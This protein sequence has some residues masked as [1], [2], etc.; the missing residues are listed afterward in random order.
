MRLA[1]RPIAGGVL[2]K[3]LPIVFVGALAV[4]LV[5][6]WAASLRAQPELTTE[7]DPSLWKSFFERGCSTLIEG[8]PI[9]R[10]PEGAS[11]VSAALSSVIGFYERTYPIL[12]PPVPQRAQRLASQS[13]SAMGVARDPGLTDA[14]ARV[15]YD[16][17]ARSSERFF[18]ESQRLRKPASEGMVRSYAIQRADIGKV[19]GLQWFARDKLQTA[20]VDRFSPPVID[21]LAI[22]LRAK[23]PVI[24]VVNGGQHAYVGVG[25]DESRVVVIDHESA[26]PLVVPAEQ[27]LLTEEDRKSS[28]EF[29]T[30]ARESLR[31]Q[32]VLLDAVTACTERR[33]EGIRF[34]SSSKLGTRVEMYT[35]SWSSDL[36]AVQQ[37]IRK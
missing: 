18:A 22:N 19:E 20:K 33:I 30:K 8:V 14:V 32:M 10:R 37:L 36:Y 24:I 21:I 7:N 1:S 17:E 3:R 16:V 28:S 9:V 29:A 5:L 35:I 15:W 23:M 27:F 12:G 34:I 11:A 13:I 25:F 2:V 4:G 6:L 31:G 26:K